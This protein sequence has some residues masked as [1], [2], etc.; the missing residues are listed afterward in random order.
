MGNHD[1]GR[2]MGRMAK[3][4]IEMRAN[5][6][7]LELLTTSPRHSENRGEII[8]MNGVGGLC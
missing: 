2:A 4:L 8:W 6:T 7:T 3:V 5:Q 1:A